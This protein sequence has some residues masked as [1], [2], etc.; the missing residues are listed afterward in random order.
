MPAIVITASVIAAIYIIYEVGRVSQRE[1]NRAAEHPSSIAIAVDVF[2]V[3][4]TTKEHHLLERGTVSTS[5]SVTISS[6]VGGLIKARNVV[7]GKKVHKGDALF[8]ID[9]TL[10]KI[11]VEESRLQLQEVDDSIVEVQ[12]LIRDATEIGDANS[13]DSLKARLDTE[14]TR[15]ELAQVRLQLTELQLE[16]HQIRAPLDAIVARTLTDLGELAAP[17]APLGILIVSDPCTVK[18]SLSAHDVADFTSGVK[19]ELMVDEV[20]RVT[21]ELGTDHGRVSPIA[22]PINQRFEVELTVPNP[23]DRFPIGT[24]VDVRMTWEAAREEMLIPLAAVRRDGDQRL[25]YRLK[26]SE[27][28]TEVQRV[29]V[30]CRNTPGI[31]DYVT[32]TQ[33]LD[34]GDEVALTNQV[35]LYDGAIVSVDRSRSAQ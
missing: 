24:R 29:V 25:V 28:S 19:C 9:D 23:N 12:K 6:P 15:R 30:E 17:G 13:I 10:A 2:L 1:A 35:L 27:E 26:R 5:A 8:H 20:E 22:D 14:A 21:V 3:T 31:P 34:F 4:P 16:R 18:F 7:S 11:Q 32:V 33:G